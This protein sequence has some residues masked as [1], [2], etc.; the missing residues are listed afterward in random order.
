[1]PFEVMIG[2][3]ALESLTTGM[4]TDPFVIYREYIQNASDSID[5][6][7]KQEILTKEQALIRITIDAASRRI[8]IED[9]GTGLTQSKAYHLLSD[10]GNSTKIQGQSR[11]F[12][13]IGRFSGLSYC[14]RL[15]FVTTY[16]D[17]ARQYTI[18]YDAQKLRD[19]ISD[20]TDTVTASHAMGTVISE[21]T[22]SCASGSHYF[23]VIMEGVHEETNLL[24]IEE[25]IRYLR[26]IAPVPY[27][28]SF[29]WGNVIEAEIA[30]IIGPIPTYRLILESSNNKVEIVKEYSDTFLLNR[31]TGATDQI[32]DIA[33][34]PLVDREGEKIGCVWYG[35]SSFVGTI[36]GREIKGLRLRASNILIGD[37]T[38]LNGIFKDSRFN[39]WVMGEV[40]IDNPRLI[41]NARRDDFEHNAD[42][43][44]LLEQLKALAIEITKTIRTASVKRNKEL[45]EAV[46]RFVEID[47]RANEAF[48]GERISSS[49]KGSVS[50]R[51]NAAKNML[52]S[53]SS[54]ELSESIRQDV[55]EQL[56]ILSGRIKGASSYKAL[57]LISGITKAEKIF[58][59]RIFNRILEMHEKE[60][61]D[62]YIDMTLEAL[63]D[64]SD[65]S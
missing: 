30:K 5:E 64:R 10:I 35:L 49:S 56:D 59:E 63:T 20:Q 23:R 54:D 40:F 41:P 39:G 1:M 9:N 45:A 57:N 24:S 4:Y 19:V 47:K 36:I 51:V 55:L 31:Q 12:R 6:A 50:S 52:A 22:N 44:Y 13:G 2:K 65:E 14:D 8:V 26:A 33:F 53:P 3:Y 42:Y 16:I 29:S 38:S 60:V 28:K 48:S 15:T 43:Y 37:Y 18:S 32:H 34:F 62:K 61:A 27:A 46:E 58:L 11:G 17:E 7:I 21:H 25:T